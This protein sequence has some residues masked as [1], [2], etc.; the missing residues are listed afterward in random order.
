MREVIWYFLTTIAAGAWIGGGICWFICVV[1]TI[2][3]IRL[4]KVFSRFLTNPLS[5]FSISEA[6]QGDAFTEAGRKPRMRAIGAVIG[7]VACWF[8]GVIALL[9]RG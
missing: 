6:F 3:L 2:R 7:F 9:I 4:Q 8:L 1:N 5:I